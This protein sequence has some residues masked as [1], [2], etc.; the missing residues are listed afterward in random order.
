M[1]ILESKASHAQKSKYDYYC[2]MNAIYGVELKR[3]SFKSWVNTN[4]NNNN[5]NNN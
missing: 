4:S 3:P 1:C 2:D 5:N